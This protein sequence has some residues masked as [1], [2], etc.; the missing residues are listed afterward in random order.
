MIKKFLPNI[1]FQNSFLIIL[2]VNSIVSLLISSFS[3]FLLLSFYTTIA[4]IIFKHTNY[5]VDIKYILFVYIILIFMYLIIYFNYI[6]VN[7]IPYNGNLNDDR[8]NEL[9]ARYF[10]DNGLTSINKIN[11]H[12]ET[13]LGNYIPA[14]NSK[15]YIIFLSFIIRIGD[16]FGGCHT[17]ALRAIN[18]WIIIF[19]A[20]Y[21]CKLIYIW[22]LKEHYI[23]LIFLFYCMFPNVVYISAHIYRD[24]LTTLIF[25]IFVYFSELFKRKKTILNILTILICYISMYYMRKDFIIFF[26]L[27][28]IIQYTIKYLKLIN[29]KRLIVFLG[30]VSC[31]LIF[32]Q[33]D[34]NL[35]IE[36]FT[37]NR[38]SISLD[39]LH[40]KI[41]SIPFIPFGIICR[42]LFYLIIPFSTT[43]FNINTYFVSINSSINHYITFGTILLCSLYPL[44]FLSIWKNRQSSCTYYFL[45]LWIGI[46]STTMGFRHI[47]AI[48]PI[49]FILIFDG[50]QY[51]SYEKIKYFFY[52]NILKK[53]KE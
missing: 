22:N 4:F 50:I 44:L 15:L 35:L 20:I 5:Q 53:R 43:I 18:A 49:M 19:I 14:H 31:F 45:M 23:N 3:C 13:F 51:I 41:M 39:S 32:F 1:T 24:T 6:N 52:K 42:L 16:F 21:I 37:K 33:S 2:V 8:V 17:F 28:N 11:H 47:M 48:Y 40:F 27:V 12:Y 7:G 30:I 10:I 26:V 9:T 34:I 36:N 29:K 25:M 38:T 46:V